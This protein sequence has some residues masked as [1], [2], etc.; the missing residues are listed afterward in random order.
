ME[1]TQSVTCA[2]HPQTLVNPSGRDHRGCARGYFPLIGRGGSDK[3]AKAPDAEHQS[4]N[5]RPGHAAQPSPG[6]LSR[7]E[8]AVV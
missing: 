6:T 8:A 1:R 5:L 7:I 4:R 3:S 2:V